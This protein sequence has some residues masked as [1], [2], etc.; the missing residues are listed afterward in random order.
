M[1]SSIILTS[2]NY[3]GEPA[4]V[5]FKPDIS[6]NVINLGSVT[7]PY[8]FNPSLLTP[9]QEIYGVYT[10]VVTDDCTNILNVIRPTSTPTPTPTFTPTMTMTQTPTTTPT[11]TIDPCYITKTPTPTVTPTPSYIPL[12][13]YYGKFT[14]STI[15][16][17]DVT[18]FEQLITNT[19]VDL[20]ITAPLGDGYCYILIPSVV[21]QP[22]QFRDSLE[23]CSG[24][25]IPMSTLSDVIILG[26]TFKVYRTFVMTN[27]TV[28]F[29]LCS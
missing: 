22:I 29:W 20:S 25:V 3:S 5:I 26:R 8:T 10:I 27:T 16:S 6:D 14:G 18:G 19:G 17:G 7:L 28:N 13:I 24:F 4:N 21:T 2:I 15:T 1:S 9:P 12:S 11:L 23:S